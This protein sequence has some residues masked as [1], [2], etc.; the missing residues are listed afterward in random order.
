MVNLQSSASSAVSQANVNMQMAVQA[1]SSEKQAV[2]SANGSLMSI[3]A[4]ASSAI[5]VA[6]AQMQSASMSAG[7]A[8]SRAQAMISAA[9]VSCPILSINPGN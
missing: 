1:S 8:V 9:D 7:S 5:S 3:Q 2:D 4:S 6:S